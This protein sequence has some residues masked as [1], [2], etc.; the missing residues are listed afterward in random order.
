MKGKILAVG[1]DEMLLSTRVSILETRWFAKAARPSE[2]LNIL[3]KEPIDIVVLCHSIE[4]SEAGSLV[5]AIR[6][7]W[8]GV[9]ILALERVAGAADELSAC[10]TAVAANGPSSLLNALERLLESG[11]PWDG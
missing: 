7:R 9:R 3:Q 8:P 10:A 11:N 5:E 6:Q 2:T 4:L 1:N